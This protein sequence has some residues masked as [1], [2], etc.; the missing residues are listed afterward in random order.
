MVD[1]MDDIDV[2]RSSILIWGA[3]PFESELTPDIY[4]S[5]ILL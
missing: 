3:G 5:P 2:L 1:N 4:L